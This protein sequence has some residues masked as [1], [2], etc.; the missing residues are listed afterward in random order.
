MDRKSFQDMNKRKAIQL[1]Y[2]YLLNK[3]KQGEKGFNIIYGESFSMANYLKPN[4]LLSMEDQKVILS[5][6]C[7]VNPLPSNMGEVIQCET[8]CGNILNNTHIMECPILNNRQKYDI[9][10]LI[11]GNM[12]EMK[13]MLAIWRNNIRKRDKMVASQDSI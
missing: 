9:N 10:N 8:G 7:Q 11:N 1:A 2:K 13:Q 6:R 4:S 3:Q 5:I 12:C